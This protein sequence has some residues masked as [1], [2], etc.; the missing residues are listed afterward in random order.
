MPPPIQP[1]PI[2]PAGACQP[3]LEWKDL[4]TPSVEYEIPTPRTVLFTPFPKHTSAQKVVSS[5]RKEN[6]SLRKQPQALQQSQLGRKTKKVKWGKLVQR[7]RKQGITKK[8]DIQAVSPK[9]SYMF[10]KP[11]QRARKVAQMRMTGNRGGAVLQPQEVIR[12]RPMM[13]YLQ[14]SV[15]D[16]LQDKMVAD[17]QGDTQ[18]QLWPSPELVSQCCLDSEGKVEFV[19]TDHMKWQ[20]KQLREIAQSPQFWDTVTLDSEE[21]WN[22]EQALGEWD[23]METGL[24]SQL[25]GQGVVHVK[26]APLVKHW[27]K[28]KFPKACSL[29]LAGLEQ[30]KASSMVQQ[31]AVKGTTNACYSA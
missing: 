7:K 25:P 14:Q 8:V 26:L 18:A 27:G 15:Q 29:N 16:M 11:A 3:R 1:S 17:K 31:W 9:L 13:K 20:V 28:S 5:S 2:T 22:W 30:I 10:N 6:S 21:L 23:N 19:A 12:D 4:S 24:G